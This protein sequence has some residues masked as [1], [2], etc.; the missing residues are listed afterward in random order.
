MHKPPSQRQ[1]KVS[2]EIRRVLSEMFLR[3]EIILL[4]G[5]SITV[6][7]VKV[8]PDLQNCTAYISPLGGSKNIAQ[9]LDILKASSGFIR[10][11]VAKNIA[12]RSAPYIMFREDDSFA[13]AERITKLLHKVNEQKS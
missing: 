9:I 12:L 11:Y 2:E 13:E 5:I 6:S 8:S 1:L 3:G 10:T 7:I 4:D